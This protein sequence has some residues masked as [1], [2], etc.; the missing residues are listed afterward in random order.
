MNQSYKPQIQAILARPQQHPETL[1]K[2]TGAP[3]FM[4]AP[5]LLCPNLWESWQVGFYGQ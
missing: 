1:Q 4:Q 3:I 5:P 2:H